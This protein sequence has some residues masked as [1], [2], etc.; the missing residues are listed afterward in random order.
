[1]PFLLAIA[2]DVTK[3]T[4]I[5]VVSGESATRTQR[6][7]DGSPAKRNDPLIVV[8]AKESYEPRCRADHI[9]IDE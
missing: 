2:E 5:C 4:A 3:L 8:G 6:I 9:V 1:M 7:I